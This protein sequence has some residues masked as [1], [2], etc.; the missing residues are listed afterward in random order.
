MCQALLLP[1]HQNYLM[2]WYHYHSDYTGEEA[3]AEKV[4]TLCN[5]AA[6]FQSPFF[7]CLT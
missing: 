5:I 2:K 7:Y 4:S 3:E 6:G 1:D